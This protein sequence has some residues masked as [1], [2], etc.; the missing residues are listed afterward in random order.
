MTN[1]NYYD[2]MPLDEFNALREA[3]AKRGTGRWN[4][5]QPVTHDGIK[6]RSTDEGNVY[7]EL[8]LLERAGKIQQLTPNPDNPKQPKFLLLPKGKC[9]YTGE[10]IRSRRYI[11]DFMYWDIEKQVFKVIDVKGKTCDKSGIPSH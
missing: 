8:R 3:E 5:N 4:R 2:G 9:P 6:F 7:L 10:T 1:S 11:A